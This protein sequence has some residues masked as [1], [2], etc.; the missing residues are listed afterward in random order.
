MIDLTRLDARGLAR[1]M[2]FS[3]LP[4]ETT[5]SEIRA[6]CALTRKYGFAAFYTS[7]A[8][9]TPLV[10]DELAGLEAVEIGTGIAFPFGSAPSAV[11]AFEV[12]DAV[13]R[14][15]TAVDMVLNIGALRSGQ[16]SVV[17]EELRDFKQAA[18][19]AVTK[20]ILEV[21]FLTDEQIA[22]ASKLVAAAGIDFVKTSTGQFE[23]P[24][25]QQFIV[26]RD[27]VR[28]APVRLKVAGIKFPRPQNA[29]AFLRVGADRLGT[30]AAPEIVDA[31]PLLRR[32]GLLAGHV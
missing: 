5:E 16:H 18:A 20:C 21:C 14:G 28:D 26:M 7:S 19:G 12:E 25:L 2:D 4:K 15:C 1:A 27:A 23:G 13:R 9:W 30:R 29:I 22:T 11:K 3:I 32:E 17:A 6:G 24:S 10:R 31:L 8:Y